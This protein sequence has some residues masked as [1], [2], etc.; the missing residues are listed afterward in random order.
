MTITKNLNDGTLNVA[1]EGRLD[2][3]TCEE[4]DSSL[5]E[6]MPKADKVILDFA[7]LDY[8]SSAGL[9]VVLQAHKAMSGKGGLSLINLNDIVK[10]VFEVTGFTDILDIR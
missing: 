9:R 4:L 10:E 7:K 2:T 1:V 8:I 3:L 5:K 6:S